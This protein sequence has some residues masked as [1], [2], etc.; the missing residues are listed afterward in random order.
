MRIIGLSLHTFKTSKI[1]VEVWFRR[2]SHIGHHNNKDGSWIKAQ[3][4]T[5]VGMGRYAHTKLPNFPF[6]IRV[7]PGYTLSFAVIS[8]GGGIAYSPGV[9]K[10]YISVANDDL[11]MFEGSYIDGY[12]GDSIASPQS[13]K[14]VRIWE[15]SMHYE[16]LNVGAYVAPRSFRQQLSLLNYIHLKR[17]VSPRRESGEC[18]DSRGYLYAFRGERVNCQWV[19]NNPS[20]GCWLV[21]DNVHAFHSCSCACAGFFSSHINFLGGQNN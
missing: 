8:K 10:Q 4:V 9:S 21:K 16:V 12:Y 11:V 5:V 6:P 20:S 7:F 14:D 15:G 2:G 17:T 18:V 3:D 19:E 13:S 1:D